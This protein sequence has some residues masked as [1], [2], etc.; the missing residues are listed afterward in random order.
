MWRL[1]KCLEEGE[2]EEEEEAVQGVLLIFMELEA[3]SSDGYAA[4]KEI[5][6]MERAYPGER[7]RTMVVAVTNM[8]RWGRLGGWA[9]LG[10]ASLAWTSV[11]LWGVV[12]VCFLF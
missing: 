12:T 11:G 6:R 5:R 2:E 4:V 9:G 8:N 7:R 3:A 10:W 1:Q